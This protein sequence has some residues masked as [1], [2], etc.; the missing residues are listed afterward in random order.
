MAVKQMRLEGSEAMDAL[1]EWLEGVDHV[2]TPKG[3]VYASEV[4][5][6]FDAIEADITAM[7][8]SLRCKG[9]LK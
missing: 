8:N 6:W 9:M 5:K 7:E 2:H 4:S 1:L 3:I